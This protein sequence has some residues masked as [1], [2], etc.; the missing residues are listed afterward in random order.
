MEIYR[1]IV[2][3]SL[4]YTDGIFGDGEFELLK[5]KQ[6]GKQVVI[7]LENVPHAPQ[8]MNRVKGRGGGKGRAGPAEPLCLWLDSGW[9]KKNVSIGLQLLLR[10]V[11]LSR[12]PVVFPACGS[13][14]P[15]A[16]FLAR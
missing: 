11:G 5:E 9:R 4:T 8:G 16:L 1:S 12:V 15:L 6:S 10:P 2:L 7:K 14:P 3:I 13:G